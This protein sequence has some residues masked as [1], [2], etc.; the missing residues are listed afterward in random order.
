MPGGH[1]RRSGLDQRRRALKR[2]IAAILAADIAGYSRLISEDE[3]ETL[4]RLADYQGLFKDQINDAGGRV[5]KTAGDSVL[6]EFPSAVDALRT[7][8]NVQESLRVRNQAF[9]ASRQMA[10]RIGLTI[11]DVV[12]HEGD[13]LGDGVNIAARLETL[14]QPGGICVSKAMYDSVVS[15]LSVGFKDLGMQTVKNIPQPV[16]A[17]AVVNDRQSASAPERIASPVRSTA[18]NLL[19][20]L[21]IA[22]ASAALV[23][24]VQKPADTPPPKSDVAAVT[25]PDPSPVMPSPVTP[26]SATQSRA[27]P[28]PA[29]AP[30][31]AAGPPSVSVPDAPAE[32][33]APS[34]AA[35]PPPAASEPQVA[36]VPPVRE[37]LAAAS[38]LRPV[39]WTTCRGDDTAAALQACGALAADMAMEGAARAEAQ[40]RLGFAQRKSGDLDAA[41]KSLSDSIAT[42][43]TAIAHSD[44]GTAYLLKGD[45]PNALA[46]YDVSI[47]LDAKN[48]E[49]WNNRAWTH[50]KAGDNRKALDDANQAVKLSANEAFVWDTRGHIHEAMGARK[51]AELDFQKALSI[52]PKLTS[53][54][55]ALRRLTGR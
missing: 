8:V 27:T 30:P 41:L 40:R 52:D 19:V 44:R 10:Y 14:A 15:K 54:Q 39:R 7:A 22:A 47:K 46:D 53:A 29:T 43:P 21:G 12:D 50:Y 24:F 35:A 38:R 11:G 17:F 37:D 9:P 25:A 3:E 36:A 4:R 45:Y 34:N 48:G 28:A 49:A 18:N 6:A 23:W 55:S 32:T 33:P 13:L 5:F 1:D 31:E 20:G 16:H 26:P 2:K 42:V 51:S